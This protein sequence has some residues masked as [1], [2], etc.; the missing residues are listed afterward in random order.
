MP[1]GSTYLVDLL[2][3]NIVS[4]IAEEWL[5]IRMCAVQNVAAMNIGQSQEG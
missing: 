4:N 1:S 5:V 2:K 3:L